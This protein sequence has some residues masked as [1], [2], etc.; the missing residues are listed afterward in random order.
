MRSDYRARHDEYMVGELKSKQ[1]VLMS[2]LTLIADDICKNINDLDEY[3][4]KNFKLFR[5]GSDLKAV[6]KSITR[7]NQIVHMIDSNFSRFSSTIQENIDIVN[8]TM[9]KELFGRVICYIDQYSI[10]WSL[11]SSKV[12]ALQ[13]EIEAELKRWDIEPFCVERVSN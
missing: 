6:Q 4:N 9:F 3:Y 2:E 5:V 13:K 7:G 12:E 1:D 10:L 11:I 8:K